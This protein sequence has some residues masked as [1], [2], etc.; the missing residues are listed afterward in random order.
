[1]FLWISCESQALNRLCM[2]T[3]LKYVDVPPK[4]WKHPSGRPLSAWRWT[5]ESDHQLPNIGIFTVWR[6]AEDFCSWS[7]FVKTPTLHFSP[8][9]V[10]DDN[11]FT[12]MPASFNAR[13]KGLFSYPKGNKEWRHKSQTKESQ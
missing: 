8:G 6:R 13:V 12:Y 3:A 2:C 11:A 10:H 4:D 1:M 9:H 5:V 7:Q